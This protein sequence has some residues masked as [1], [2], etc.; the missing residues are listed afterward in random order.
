M[1]AFLVTMP[2][3]IRNPITTGRLIAMPASTSA[4]I[5]P[6]I[7]SGSD[8]RIETGTTK[9]ENSRTSTT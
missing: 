1:I 5:A 6:P 8:S 9:L 7:E 3:S 4:P 2:I